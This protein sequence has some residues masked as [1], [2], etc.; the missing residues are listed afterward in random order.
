MSWWEEDQTKMSGGRDT[1]M[2]TGTVWGPG[3]EWYVGATEHGAEAEE[4]AVLEDPV[5]DGMNGEGL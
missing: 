5:Q 1:E 2:E 4:K 3:E